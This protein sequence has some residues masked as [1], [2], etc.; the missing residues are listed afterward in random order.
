M[1]I[2]RPAP[3]TTRPGLLPRRQQPEANSTR[4]NQVPRAANSRDRVR[5]QSEDVPPPVLEMPP[6]EYFGLGRNSQPTEVDW[7][8]VQRRLDALKITRFH[9][10]RVPGGFR[11][12]CVIPGS[13]GIRIEADGLTESEAIDLALSRAE[14]KQRQLAAKH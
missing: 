14:S 4:M 8:V 11:F 1:P 10:Q 12:T 2:T 5:L 6:P 7:L 3:A 9:M 13:P